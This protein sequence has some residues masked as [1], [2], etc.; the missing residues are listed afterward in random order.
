MSL[1][2]DQVSRAFAGVQAVDRVDLR[3]EPGTAAA[4]LG[5]NGAGKTSLVNL[6]AG[7]VPPQHGRVTVDGADLTG[8]GP[9]AF[10]RAGVVR[11][12]QSP[13]LF[14]T[15]PALDNVLVGAFGPAPPPVLRALL[16]TG[17]FRAGERG[18]HQRAAASL[19]EVGLADGVL[20]TLADRPVAELSHGQRRRVELARA[21]AAAPRYLVLDEP[22]AGL[23]PSAVDDLVDVLRGRL[24]AGI[25]L[26]LVEHDGDLVRRLADTVIGLVDGRVVATGRYDAVRAHPA[27]AGTG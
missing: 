10:A 16:R 13:R 8:R 25:G 23:D 9:R 22:G 1:A 14:E 4:L 5:P 19:A 2:L 26:L 21:L 18:L 27:L 7:T 17:G 24:A 11:T 3:V 15:M 12:F 20:G 6:A